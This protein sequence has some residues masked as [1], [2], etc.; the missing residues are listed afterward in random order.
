M[1]GH[2]TP[3][4]AAC[5]SAAA[6]CRS[7]LSL[8]LL[9]IG[10][11]QSRKSRAVQSD[12]RPSHSRARTRSGVRQPGAAL[13]FLSF[14]RRCARSQAR[15]NPEQSK[16]MPGHRTPET[17]LECGSQV[18]LWTFSFSAPMRPR[19]KPEAIQSSPKRCPAIALQTHAAGV[20]QPG[21]ALDFL[22]FCTNA[23]R[24]QARSNPEQSKAMPGHRTP[25]C[26]AAIPSISSIDG[27]LILNGLVLTGTESGGA[28]IQS[29]EA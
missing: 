12:A 21:A 10:R 17:A 18:P 4:T 2:R 20:R 25:E 15:S 13:D 19:T 16:A 24:D 23:A 5:W 9:P 8:F 28:A 29:G 26:F 11:S 22:F 14:L 6:R 3:E 27:D 7:G 1:P